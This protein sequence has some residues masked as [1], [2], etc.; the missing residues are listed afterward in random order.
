M[1]DPETIGALLNSIDTR[2]RELILSEERR[3]SG[4]E[5]GKSPRTQQDFERDDEL[6]RKLKDLADDYKA[7]SENKSTRHTQ[8]PWWPQ[9]IVSSSGSIKRGAGAA[10]T[11]A[12]QSEDTPVLSVDQQLIADEPLWN[13]FTSSYVYR[14]TG[15]EAGPSKS[16]Y[17]TPPG[18]IEEEAGEGDARFVATVSAFGVLEHA[19]S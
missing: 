19:I 7:I 17:Q 6:A 8:N 15:F 2:H 11:F 13:P 1:E 10:Q 18:S 4:N 16:G 14:G 9:R 3:I 12:A 5:K